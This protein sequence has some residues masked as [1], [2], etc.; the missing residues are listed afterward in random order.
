MDIFLV[1]KLHSYLPPA[2][3]DFPTVQ[4]FFYPSYIHLLA[5]FFPSS[6]PILYLPQTTNVRGAGEGQMGTEFVSATLLLGGRLV[7]RRAITWKCKADTLRRAGDDETIAI[8][9]EDEGERR[10]GHGRL[11]ILS[12]GRSRSISAQASICLA[13]EWR[14]K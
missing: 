5:P 6:F 3:N 1:R 7:R 12:N 2:A 11:Y 9:I 14:E 10:S 4:T 13:K 8:A